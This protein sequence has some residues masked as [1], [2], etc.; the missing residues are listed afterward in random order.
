MNFSGESSTE[1]PA[2][3]LARWKR[4]FVW[5]VNMNKL[6]DSRCIRGL[7]S[8]FKSGVVVCMVPDHGWIETLTSIAEDMEKTEK[9]T[10][11]TREAWLKT[12]GL[13]KRLKGVLRRAG[14]HSVNEITKDNLDGV[15]QCGT[16]T[17]RD[18][19][20]FR[21]CEIAKTGFTEMKQNEH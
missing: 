16:K 2:P 13:P 8:Q 12:T 11:Q 4:V 17:I 1:K 15:Y 14:I 19:I 7:I 18:L 3:M 20:A 21:D 6:Y 5:M 9:R 10:S